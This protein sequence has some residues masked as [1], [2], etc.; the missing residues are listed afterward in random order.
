MIS[1]N[2]LEVV[3]PRQFRLMIN[4]KTHRHTII[5]ITAYSIAEF[6]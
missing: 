2:G 1:Q 4:Y 5:S 6:L 3:I